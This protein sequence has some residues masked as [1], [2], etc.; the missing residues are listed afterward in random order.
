VSELKDM[1]ERQ[2]GFAT[3][4]VDDDLQRDN[5]AEWVSNHVNAAIEELIELKREV[6]WKWWKST[7]E[8]A[9]QEVNEEAMLKEF[10]D[11]MC[12]MLNIANLMGW[13]AGDLNV[14]HAAVV[15]QNHHRFAARAKEKEAANDKQ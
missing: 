9:Q 4:V 8:R 7:E 14:S 6:P 5:L 3:T 1:L 12:F 15:A 10:T 2:Y 11:V 13:N